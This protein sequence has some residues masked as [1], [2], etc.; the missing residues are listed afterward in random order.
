[1]SFVRIDPIRNTTINGRPWKRE[2]R[3]HVHFGQNGSS[4]LETKIGGRPWERET[5]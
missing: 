5:K 2:A 1:M 4:Y 3:W